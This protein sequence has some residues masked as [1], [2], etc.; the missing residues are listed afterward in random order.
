MNFLSPIKRRLSNGIFKSMEIIL[1]EAIISNNLEEVQKL[2]Q[3]DQTLSMREISEGDKTVVLMTLPS[4]VL[5][6]IFFC[7]HT[8]KVMPRFTM[9]VSIILK[10]RLLNFYS[11]IILNFVI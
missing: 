2:I 10:L 1:R 11:K 7:R 4:I 8:I 3:K 6:F 5:S 9:P